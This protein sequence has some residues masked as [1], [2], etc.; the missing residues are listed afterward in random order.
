MADQDRAIKRSSFLSR[1]TAPFFRLRAQRRTERRRRQVK[2]QSGFDPYR[3]IQLHLNGIT[4]AYTGEKVDKA[5]HMGRI[6][7]GDWDQVIAPFESLDVWSAFRD[8][9]I[10]GI[11]WRET[12]FYK[13]MLGLIESGIPRWDCHNQAE[14]DARYCSI[15]KLYQIIQTQGYRA[16][17]QLPVAERFYLENVDE[18]TVSIARDGEILFED[19]R[20]RFSIA[21][22]LELET[23]PV[24]VVWR[25][26]D[27]FDFRESIRRHIESS[28]PID[29]LLPHPDLTDLSTGGKSSE[30][31]EQ[32]A[33]LFSESVDAYR[34][35]SNSI[36]DR[37]RFAA[38]LKDVNLNILYLHTP[39]ATREGDATESMSPQVFIESLLENTHLTQAAII[40]ESPGNRLYKLTR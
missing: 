38:L 39:S 21:K 27:W 8:H 13:R 3:V 18:I 32:S 11:P 25:H 22:I 26:Q 34:R 4:N 33:K 12:A 24:Q 20:H 36:S 1:L 10:A 17:A 31:S 29:T 14:L 40:A 15:D 9:Y 23:I 2:Q 6:V 16:Q 19:G 7:A 28:G 30:S 5:A 35:Y 37:N